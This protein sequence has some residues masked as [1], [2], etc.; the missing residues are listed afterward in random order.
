VRVLVTGNNGYIGSIMTPMLLAAGHA[1]NGLDA[2]YYARCT[3]VGAVPAVRT[4]HKDIRQVTADDLR[5]YDAVIHL[6]ALSND[7]LGNLNPDLTYAINERASVELARLAKDASVERFLYA[8]SCSL[9][10]AAGDEMLTESAAFNPVTPYGESKVLA[11][12]AISKLADDNFSPTYLRNATAYGVSPRHRFDIVLNNLVAWAVA[13]GKVLIKSDGTPWRPIVHIEDISR[14]FLAVLHAPRALVHNE[15]FNVGVN[16]ENYRI[17]ELAE[18]V[19]ETVPGCEIEYAPGASPDLRNYRVDFSKIEATLPAF[20]PQW[21]A[22]RGARELYAAYR[23][24]DLKVE[25]FEGPRYR[26]VDHIKQ[27]MAQGLLDESLLWR[28]PEPAL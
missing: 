28:Q 13:T 19:R 7:P 1:V 11:E 8:S 5:G 17:R 3:F 12:Q 14:A 22:R 21:D 15:P 23:A 9:Y 4:L 24:V 18:I 26:R 2:D 20:R 6:A 27:L 10:G 25:E 16:R